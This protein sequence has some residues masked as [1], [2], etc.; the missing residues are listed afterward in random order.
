[1]PAVAPA[2][3]MPAVAPALPAYASADGVRGSSGSYD[4]SAS[5]ISG[6]FDGKDGDCWGALPEPRQP[7]AAV[8]SETPAPASTASIPETPAASEPDPRIPSHMVQYVAAGLHGGLIFTPFAV[9]GADP[10]DAKLDEAYELVARHGLAADAPPRK[11]P[12]DGG[13]AA[14]EGP[15]PL[16]VSKGHAGAVNGAGLR[17]GADG[18]APGCRR[19]SSVQAAARRL[20]ALSLGG[21]D[22]ANASDPAPPSL[23]APVPAQASAPAS[24]GAGAATLPTSAA[25]RAPLPL[26]EFSWRQ[27]QSRKTVLEFGRLVR[28]RRA[29]HDV[30]AR[31]GAERARAAADAASGRSAEDGAPCASPAP[32]PARAGGDHVR[33]I[34]QEEAAV[35]QALRAVR[36]SNQKRARRAGAGGAGA[37]GAPGGAEESSIWGFLMP[38][39]SKLRP[40]AAAEMARAQVAAA[41]AVKAMQEDSDARRA[42]RGSIRGPSPLSLGGES[43]G[44]R[45]PRSAPPAPMYA[46]RGGAAEDASRDGDVRESADGAE[47]V[48]VDGGPPFPDR[49]EAVLT[50]DDATFLTRRRRA[51]ARES[52]ASSSPMQTP[53]FPRALSLGPAPGPGPKAPPKKKRVSFTPTNTIHPI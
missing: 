29:E 27:S 7:A 6:S 32:A 41:A 25:P 20:S 36:Q 46:R 52:L 22:S 48:P 45:R 38:R 33:W 28:E 35:A 14:A 2:L 51:S 24:A 12:V 31:S 9:V 15:P 5:S 40:E 34:A 23:C 47:A 43:S 3:R 8:A 49:G 13:G 53:G 30:A 37:G 26:R 50:L 1:M 18:G 16:A 10:A 11:P 39:S 4:L 21:T 19:A 42:Q 44:G 17:I